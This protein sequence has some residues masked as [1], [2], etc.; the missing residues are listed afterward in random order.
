MIVVLAGVG[1]YLCFFAGQ[2]NTLERLRPAEA[3]LFGK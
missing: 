3:A 2:G 1:L